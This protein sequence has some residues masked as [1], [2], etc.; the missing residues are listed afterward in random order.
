[1]KLPF[2][3][4]S[5]DFDFD[6]DIIV[7]LHAAGFRIAEIPIPTFYGD[8]I[9]HVNGMRYAW[10]CIK[11]AV[12][13]RLMQFEIFYDPKFDIRR[14]SQY[15]YTAKHSSTS[16]HHYIRNLP[17]LLKSRILDVGGGSGVAVGQS[18]AARG[19]DVTSIDQ[20]AD[21]GDTAVRQY[22]VDLDQPWT[23]QFP[24]DKFNCVLALDVLE[25]LKSPELGI[26]EIFG[27]LE[28]N[29]KLYASTGNVAYLPLRIVLL[30]GWFNY[31]RRGILDM[32][33]CRLFTIGS[34]KRLLKNA[35]FRV[36]RV[37]GFGPPV[38]DSVA[39][40]GR[41]LN[42]L[43]RLLSFGAKKW[44]SLFAYQILAECTRTDSPADLM[45]QTFVLGRDREVPDSAINVVTEQDIIPGRSSTA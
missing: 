45:P 15:I 30:F 1:V 25:H 42:L 3:N 5:L 28:R 4:N 34:F 37:I 24:S 10:Q 23:P 41:V 22:A 7:Q 12:K 9:C 26:K 39:R 36:E 33:H 44:P 27:R 32:T 38:A 17:L 21:T 35:G 14:E 43:D 18:L 6:A 31:G 8:E 2:T 20:D 13:Y 40:G 29:G 19:M 16:L 11:T